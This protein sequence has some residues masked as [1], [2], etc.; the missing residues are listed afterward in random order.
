MRACVAQRFETPTR[1]PIIQ[2]YDRIHFFGYCD[3]SN[4][5]RTGRYLLSLRTEPLKRYM[6][7]DDVAVIG[8]LDSR[9]DT[10]SG[11]SRR[12]PPE[13]GIRE[14]RP[15]GWSTSDDLQASDD[16][17]VGGDLLVKG[18]LYCS[19]N[20]AVMH[21]ESCT[22]WTATSFTVKEVDGGTSNTTFD[23]EIAA[24]RKGYETERLEKAGIGE[25]DRLPDMGAC[26]GELP[27]RTRH[28]HLQCTPLPLQ[29]VRQHRLYQR[30]MLGH[31]V[32]GWL[33]LHQVRE[34]PVRGVHRQAASAAR[35]FS[36][37]PARF[38][39]RR[40]CPCPHH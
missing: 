22:G 4:W 18:N 7:Q 25:S 39:R 28:I 9:A 10:D 37:P 27:R 32:Q 15:P 1:S 31:R 3:E 33:A 38:A 14:R 6:Q 13:M 11:P 24:P 21:T 8:A 5:D 34:V 12:P 2:Q 35:T 36:G 19:G 26:R 40:W 20:K 17:L 23:W 29:G 16:L 30:E